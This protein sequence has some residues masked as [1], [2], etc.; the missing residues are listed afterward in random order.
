MWVRFPP[1]ALENRL[2]ILSIWSI[3]AEVKGRGEKRQQRAEILNRAAIVFTAAC[4]ETFVEDLAVEAFDFML[5]HAPTPD[6]I[7]MR[8]RTLDTKHL[9]DDKDERKIWALAG[10]G[11]RET[12]Q[13]HRGAVIARWTTDFHTPRPDRVRDLFTALLDVP[14][15]TSH[16]HWTDVPTVEAVAKL[17]EYL[18]IRGNISH[19][20]KHST[21]VYKS[22]V[23]GFVSHV[24]R[25]VDLT[26]RAVEAHVK[27][28][29]GKPPW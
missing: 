3:Y 16:W 1:P 18:D 22:W 2:D 14:D 24:A 23:K 6:V 9:R 15:I 11:W 26:D 17:D 25:L 21:A 20:T 10:S 8:V 5:A 28:L 13:S 19:R 4:W 27:R 12:R 29:T 7:P